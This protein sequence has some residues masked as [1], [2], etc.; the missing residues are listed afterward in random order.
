M[1]AVWVN[2]TIETVFKDTPFGGAGY[3]M[4]AEQVSPY[5]PPKK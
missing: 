5:V 1:G 2:G 4:K 3:Q